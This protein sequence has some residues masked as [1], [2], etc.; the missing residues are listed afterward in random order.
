MRLLGDLEVRR[1]EGPPL[2]LPPSRRTRALLGYLAAIG[3]PRSRGALCD[4][5]WDGPDDP[6]AA[7]RWSLTKLRAVVNGG[8]IEPLRADRERVLFDPHDCEIDIATLPSLDGALDALPL[9][10][11][12]TAARALQGEFLDGLDLPACYRFHHWCMG[13]RE[14]Y[15]RLRRT[16]LD[17]LIRRLADAPQ[18]A[19]PHGRAMVAA[20]PLADT[21]HATLVRLL[22]AAGRYP[23]A[24]THYAWARELLRREISLPDGGPLDDAIRA[25]RRAQRQAAAQAASTDDLATPDAPPEPGTPVAPPHIDDPPASPASRSPLVGRGD[26]C[27]AIDTCLASPRRPRLLLFTGEP[28]IGKTRLLDHLAERAAALGRRVL[29]ARCFEAEAV[30]P[31]GFWLDALRGVPIDDIDAPLLARAAPLLGGGEGAG[32]REQLFDGTAGLLSALARRQALVMVVDDLQWIDAASAALLHYVAR[33]LAEAPAAMLMAAAARIGEI[34]DNAG[35][36][37]LLQSLARDDALVQRA[38]LPLCEEDVRPWLGDSLPDIAAALR[39]TGG[40]PLLLIE[41]AR[42]GRSASP[43]EARS[44]DAL[45][46]DR[47]RTVDEP[48]RDLLGWAAALGG[49]FDAERLAFAAGQAVPVVIAR[50]TAFER[51]GLLRTTGEGGFD[52]THGLVREAVYR[53]LSTARRRALHRQIARAFEA[54]STDDPWLHGAVVHHAS[55]AGDA[56][57]AT[58]A[59][60][61]AGQHWLSV[62][63]N[64]EAAQVAERGLALVDELPPGAPH[65]RLEIGLLRLRVAAASAPGGRRLPDLSERIARAIDAALALG[66]HAEASSAWEILSYW[67]QHVGDAG[68]ARDASLAAERCTRLADASTRCRQLANSGRCLI[69]IEADVERGRT[70]LDEAAAM[71]DGLQLPVMELEWGRGLVARLESDLPAAHASLLR[72]VSLARAAANHWREYECMLALATVEY[73]MAMV[74]DLLRHVDD[75]RA[76]ARRM[77]EPQ[78]PFAD[79]LAALARLRQGDDTAATAVDASLAALHE[80]DDKAHLAY[81]LNEVAAWALLAGD[82]AAAVRHAEAA[83]AAATP[84]RRPAEIERARATLAAAARTPAP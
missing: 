5:L 69:D 45:I 59:A 81:V 73:E 51:H 46:D 33:R 50:L 44:L 17:T 12:E 6:R 14:R 4:L 41:L 2:P 56:L 82:A 38:L 37:S 66:L 7:L 58:R 34:D 3:A 79:A 53:G 64:V 43:G 71:A 15:A 39:E 26:E 70:L 67:H 80:R 16:A 20:D 49:A 23:D 32:S 40:N 48:S 52:F 8:G 30:R 62:F 27:R 55:L 74:D 76:A 57:V 28:G 18:R 21:A 83:L 78:V 72:A 47:L 60:L 13:E 84:V 75:V 36:R 54:A 63:A 9:E 77:G 42:A 29:R 65:A 68:A 24:E 11:L 25:V 35:A 10:S 31:Y 19:L 22:A 1:G 61:A